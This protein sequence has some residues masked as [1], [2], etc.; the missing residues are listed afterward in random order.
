[1]IHDSLKFKSYWLH[2]SWSPKKRKSKSK[3]PAFRRLGDYGG[4]KMKRD[5]G[6][7]PICFDFVRGRCYRGASC[8]YLHQDSSNR[9][10]SRLHK[11]KEQYPE[12]SP[13][14]NNIDL[15]EG[16]KDIPGK[17]SVQEHDED[18]SQPVQFS[19]DT[20]VGSFDAP[21]DGD[22]ANKREET[23]ARDSMLAVV[24]DQDGKYESCREAA[25]HVL[26]MQ[27]VH[28]G[29]AK[30]ATQVTEETHQPLS[31]DCF[32]SQPVTDVDNLKLAGDI[33]RGTNFS[34]E[35]KE[36]QQSQAN[37]STPALQNAPHEPHHVDGSSMS[38]SSPDQM[39]TTFSNKVPASE[40]HPNKIS[41]DPLPP[42]ASSTIQ[43]VSDEGFLSRSLAPK[44]LSS[45]GSSAVD[46]PHPPSQLPPPPPL[47]QG[48]N[49]PH[50]PQPLKDHNVM[51]PTTNFPF[52]SASGESFSTYQALPSNQ[53]PHF[54]IP[55]NSSWTSM[56]PPPPLLSHFNDSAA[57]A[58]TV[59]AGVPSQYPQ[60]HLP[61]RNDLISQSF[62]TSDPTKLSTHSQPSEFQHRAYPSMHEPHL[63]PLH[64]EPK[65]LHLSNPSSQQFGGPNLVREDRFAQFPV[66]GL[67]PSSS[68]A[69]GSIYPQPPS[70]LRGSPVNKV[71]PFPVD[72]LPPGEILQSSSQIHTFSQQKQPPYDLP[73]STSEGF[74][75]HLSVPG[76][77]SSSM[78]RYPSDLLDRNQSSRLGFGGSRIAAHYNPY[79]ST[80]DQPLSTKFSSNV[81]RQ[82]KDTSYRN[83]YDMPFGLSHFPADKQGVSSLASRQTISSPNSATAGRQILSRSG[84][85]QYDPL[86]DSIEP[87]SNSYVKLDHVQKLEPTINSE[88]ILRHSGSHKPLD[89]EENNKH[90]EVEAVALTTSVEN[91]EYGETADAEVGAVENGSPSSPIDI[92]NT[93]AGEVEIDQIKSPGKSKKSKDSRSMK[94]FKIALADFVKEVLKPSW[95]Q[96]NMSKEA[97]KTIVKKTVDKVSGAMK[98][99][100]IPKSEA[101]INHY[102]DSSQRK[103]TKLV[104]VILL[105]PF[106]N[107]KMILSW[108]F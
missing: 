63:P 53:Q 51:P 27:E 5:K 95:R 30:A 94:L 59:A 66:Q 72:D 39:L 43:L 35:S 69:Q 38:G 56:R 44:E 96:G 58:V 99:H 86:F 90:K 20:T 18:K 107:A 14:S 41:P 60:T 55:P 83:K 64:M 77:I 21:K 15:R 103:L 50:L 101:K 68:F 12:D 80:F 84:G 32:P 6:Q 49:A 92:A 36:I 19:Q 11:N 76:K 98:R 104:M 3:S 81:F 48:V 13:N 37:L 73:H 97:F 91:D 33:S 26:E 10:G 29:P 4:D 42:E 2:L 79:A 23:S 40:P 31:V 88:I 74:S 17:I 85:D 46:F 75:V 1:M 89:V 45:S 9:D 67:I 62:A 34:S 47:M 108:S 8:R 65:S 52:Q 61:P 25:A 100:Q 106:G 87:S 22:V 57:N 82:E 71:Q 102:I 78:S 54:S 93:A 7:M 16:S 28:E 105:S 70:Y 24:S